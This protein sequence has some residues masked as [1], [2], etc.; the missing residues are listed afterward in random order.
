MTF[1]PAP[2]AVDGARLKSAHM[3]RGT[4]AS[5]SGV[6]GLVERVDLKVSQD[7]TPGPRLL[8]SPG[9]AILLNRYQ[10]TINESYVVSNEGTH[11]VGPESMP[12]AQT[13]AKSYLVLITI[14]DFAFSQSGHPWA[15]SSIDPEDAP[16]YQYVRP[17]ILPCPAGTTSFEQLALDFPAY[18][19]ARL[20]IPS[21]A[22][23]I[24]NAMI[25]DL[26]AMARPRTSEEILFKVA[27]GSNYLNAISPTFEAWAAMHTGIKIPK[28]ASVAKISGYV[29]SAI[30]HKA[31]NG[32]IRVNIVGAG[33]TA[34]TPFDR[35][36]P[37]GTGGTPTDRTGI[38]FGGV[39]NVASVAGTTRTVQIEGTV[40]SAASQNGLEQDVF[41][42][43]MIRIRFEEAPV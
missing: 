31:T 29:E 3:R 13:G 14:A 43:S 19:L 30:A 8:I 25:T 23:T 35:S 9:N 5:T 17:F 6:E 2:L 22:T 10:D 39:V 18:A 32:A 36:T 41:T 37:S 24:T 38:N 21:G 42:S 40:N 4:Y 28:W 15:P 27:T 12:T 1:F 16:D 34:I 26:R 7:V 20:D 11:L 33:A